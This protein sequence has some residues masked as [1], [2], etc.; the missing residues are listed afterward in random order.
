MFPR[1]KESLFHKR[2]VEAVVNLPATTREVADSLSWQAAKTRK[3]NRSC[4]LQVMTFLRFL[5][6]QD[7]QL[8]VMAVVEV[9]ETLVSYWIFFNGLMILSRT[10]WQRK[11]INILAMMFKTICFR[12]WSIKLFETLYIG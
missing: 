10:F 2:A 9:M 5:A 3:G 12:L 1:H 6:R 4:L 7:L 11:R 8:E